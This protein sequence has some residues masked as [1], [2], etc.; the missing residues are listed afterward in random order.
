M[1]TISFF[2]YFGD[3]QSDAQG[4]LGPL[5]VIQWASGSMLWYKDVALLRT[6]STGVI[7][8]TWVAFSDFQVVPVIKPGLD[9]CKEYALCSRNL[10]SPLLFIFKIAMIIITINIKFLHPPLYFG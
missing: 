6:C 4:T 8:D 1:E 2:I 5:S 7:Q 3:L 10:P 9:I